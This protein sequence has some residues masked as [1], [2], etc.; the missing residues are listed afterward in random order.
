MTTLF[1]G[2]LN[3]AAFYPRGAK[4]ALK[5]LGHNP[6]SPVDTSKP[7]VVVAAKNMADQGLT[8]ARSVVGHEYLHAGVAALADFKAHNI[9]A[10][11]E[12]AIARHH[13]MVTGSP[14]EA[15]RSKRF[16]KETYKDPTHAHK[17]AKALYG[18]LNEKTAVKRENI[19][20]AR[21]K[22]LDE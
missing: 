13:D 11:L 10:N 3:S 2:N 16:F 15:E 22:A 18:K 14:E 12:E 21:N 6:A 9:G 7:T 1:K 4:G 19:I 20:R 17:V 5:E 8:T